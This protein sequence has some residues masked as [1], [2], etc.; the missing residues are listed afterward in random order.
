MAAKT[1]EDWMSEHKTVVIT[2]NDRYKVGHV[3]HRMD[4]AITYY[5]GHV[6][7]KGFYETLIDLIVERVATRD[8]YIAQL[9]IVDPDVDPKD[10]EFRRYFYLLK[11]LLI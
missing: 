11:R 8:E 10:Y 9:R 5:D 1:I 2:S 7:V 3:F 4:Q 6:I